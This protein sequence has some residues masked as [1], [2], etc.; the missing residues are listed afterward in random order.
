[1]N[2]EIANLKSSKDE[3]E[4]EKYKKEIDRKTSLFNKFLKKFG[5]DALIQKNKDT[6]CAIHFRFYCNKKIEW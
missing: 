5:E 6:Y 3:A 4:N 2:E 1:M